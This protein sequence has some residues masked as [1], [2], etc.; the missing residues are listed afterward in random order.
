MEYSLRI[1]VG[2]YEGSLFVLNT[3]TKDKEKD[4]ATT[5]DLELNLMAG[6]SCSIGALKSIAISET[7]R[8]E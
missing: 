8:Y 5:S 7:G 6:F 4:S 1:S 2:S 3:S